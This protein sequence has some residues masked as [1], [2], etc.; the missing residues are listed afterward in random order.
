M[1]VLMA[2]SQ[3]TPVSEGEQFEVVL[4]LTIGVII[5]CAITRLANVGWIESQL[6]M[7]IYDPLGGTLVAHLATH[8]HL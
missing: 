6:G 8:I 2:A 7:V 5:D 1:A 4:L 3:E